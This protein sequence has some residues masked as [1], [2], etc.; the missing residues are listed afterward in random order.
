MN[1]WGWKSGVGLCLVVALLLTGCA[2]ES[3]QG[4]S[5]SAAPVNSGQPAKDDA[6]KL[7]PATLKWLLPGDKMK[8]SALVWKEFNKQLQAYLPNTTVEFEYVPSSEYKEKWQLI[9]ASGEQVDIAWTGWLVSFTEEVNKGAYLALDDLI[10]KYGKDILGEVPEYVLDLGKVGGRTYSVPSYKDMVDLKIGM[11][12]HKEL[13]EKYWDYEKAEKVFFSREDRVLREEDYDILEGYMA[14]LKEAGELRK[15]I[16]DVN[17]YSMVLGINLG[18]QFSVLHEDETYTVNIRQETPGAKLYFDKMADWFAK[19]YVR[20]DVLSNKNRRQDEGRVDGYTLW[21]QTNFK[22][23]SEKET[24]VAGFPIEVIPVEKDW[25]ISTLNASSATVIPRT[26]KHPER[27]MMLINLMNTERGKDLMNLLV[28][29]I[30]GVHYNKIGENR[31]ELLR[32][33]DGAVN[34]R[35]DRF[36]PGN[37]LIT[38]DT[39][40]DLEGF[41]SYIKNEV[42]GTAIV[43]PLVGMKVDTGKISTELAQVNAIYS[44]YSGLALGA[45]PNHEV[46]YKEMI[47]KMYASGAEKV[48]RELQRQVDE[49]LKSKGIA[50][51]AR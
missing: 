9:A 41:S 2:G 22:G 8:D 14:R 51:P 1:R 13:A 33:G 45:L 17:L 24:A 47:N 25:R 16:S 42:N 37:M 48:K 12:T 49:Y 20:E 28:H 26:A 39:T 38:Y 21:F 29:G 27:A 32:G 5:N 18:G 36:I 11:R 44:E 19:G 46:L 40:S 15:G 31:I 6:P 7:E 43:H 50:V 35:L 34:Y 3:S 23:Q 4:I 30:E 10:G